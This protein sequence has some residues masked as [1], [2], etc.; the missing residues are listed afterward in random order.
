MAIPQI[1]RKA[2]KANIDLFFDN[3]GKR[4]QI[5]QEKITYL[6]VHHDYE[7]QVL[8]LIYVS[9]VVDSDLYTDILKYKDSAKFYLSI[10]LSN[11]NSNTSISKN[12]IKGNFNYIP[13]TT[14]PNF[15]ED[16]SDPNSMIDSA[17]RRI[18]IGLVSMELINKLRCNFNSVY[19]NIDQKT[20]IGIAIEGTKCVVENIKYNKSYESILVPPISS[21]Y[22]FLEFIFK[23]NYD[24]DNFYDTNFRYFMDFERS[25]LLSKCGNPVSAEDG[26]LDTIIVDIRSI[27]DSEAYYDGVSVKN[28]AYYIY[29]NPADSNVIV[30]KSTEKVSNQIIAVDEVGMQKISLDINNSIGSTD[31]SMFVRTENAALYKNEL[32]TNTIITEIVKQHIDPS[33]FTPNKCIIVN[34]FGDYSKYNGKYLMMYRKDFYKCVAGEFIVSCNVGLKKIGNIQPAGIVVSSRSKAVV[35]RSATKKSTSKQKNTS[36]K[37][38]IGS[39]RM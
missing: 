1:N 13:S 4:K 3:N 14:N 2:Y 34:N 38:N 22:K 24:K 7:S 31:K 5:L 26:S 25:Y 10:D 35:K 29:L 15:Q 23:H 12:I 20:L 30:N 16:I 19:N 6:M 21:R 32:E 28:N 37:R 9:V 18:M 17:F 36:R 39:D 8:P 33:I 27:T 11:R